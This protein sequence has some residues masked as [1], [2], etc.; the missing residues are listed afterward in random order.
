MWF[1]PDV[2]VHEPLR[3]LVK[4]SAKC[5][6]RP[7][8]TLRLDDLALS[9][10]KCLGGLAHYVLLPML[11]LMCVPVNVV[12]PYLARYLN[13]ECGQSHLWGLGPNVAKVWPCRFTLSN[14]C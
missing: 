4:L 6:A 8:R 3:R 5:P 11:L 14:P 2:K 13:H 7:I 10:I 12:C 1:V 9:L